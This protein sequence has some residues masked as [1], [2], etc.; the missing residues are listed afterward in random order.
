[1]NKIVRIGTIKGQYSLFCRIQLDLPNNLS[2]TGVEGP[3]KS[4]N[5]RG[6]CDQIV[7]HEWEITKYAPGWSRELE[8]EFRAVWDR[9][10]MNGMRAGTHPQME[11]LRAIEDEFPGYPVSHYEWAVDKL[12]DAGLDPDPDTGYRYGSAWLKEPL[13]QS[14]I[15]FLTSL[16]DTDRT[17]AWV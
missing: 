10:H 7:M 6:A 1:M 9:W 13:P 5:C 11:Y 14:V 12:K 4:G 15:D 8:Q 16:P 3:L 2:I 17:P